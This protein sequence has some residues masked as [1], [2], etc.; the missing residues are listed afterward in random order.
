VPSSSPTA[1]PP[2]H[3]GDVDAPSPSPP[4]NRRPDPSHLLPPTR[5]PPTRRCRRFRRR[6]RARAGSRSTTPAGE[7]SSTERIGGRR[8]SGGG[9]WPR[10]MPVPAPNTPFTQPPL[11]SIQASAASCFLARSPRPR[12][13]A[14]SPLV[15][16]TA[17][18]L[19]FLARS[20]AAARS[21]VVPRAPLG[22]PSAPRGRPSR[23]CA[24]TPPVVAL[25][26]GHSHVAAARA[27]DVARSLHAEPPLP[28]LC[29]APKNEKQGRRR[30]RGGS[31]EARELSPAAP[32]PKPPPPG[33]AREGPM[34]WPRPCAPAVARVAAPVRMES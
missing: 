10:P 16:S 29:R 18:C 11:H 24:A 31:R 1:S 27:R 28:C 13:A 15:Q 9:A 6:R 22:S 3:Q 5:P 19:F 17:A 30:G 12:L 14:R 34:P 4:P 33:E 26:A 8:E 25:A 32:L 2:L 23:V 20:P 7:S 21:A